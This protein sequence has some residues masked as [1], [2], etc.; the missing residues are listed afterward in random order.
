MDFEEIKKILNDLK[1]SKI[2]DYEEKNNYLRLFTSLYGK[3]MAIGF[4][5]FNTNR[6]IN[7]LYDRIEDINQ[8]ITKK[9]IQDFKECINLFQK[10]KEFKNN[11]DLNEYIK[12]ELNNEQ[13][14]KFEIYSKNYSLIIELDKKDDSSLYLYDNVNDIIQNA[15]LIIKQDEEDFCYGEN[16]IKKTSMEKLVNFK[17]RINIK[18]IEETNKLLIKYKK[19]IFLKKS[20]LI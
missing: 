5:L 18:K 12:K 3:E 1:R 17:N 20:Y 14:S 10:F 4:L 15:N 13:I 19:L 2:Y 9:T 6:D 16:N 11:F 7:Y 8:I